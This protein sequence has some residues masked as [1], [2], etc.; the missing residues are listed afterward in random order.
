MLGKVLPVGA[1]V[2]LVLGYAAFEVSVVG[3]SQHLFEPLHS[4][5]Q[6]VD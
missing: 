6:F 4:F 5:D 2:A 3:S 1:F